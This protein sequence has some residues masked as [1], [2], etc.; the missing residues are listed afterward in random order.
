MNKPIEVG[1]SFAV[2]IGNGQFCVI[3]IVKV[4]RDDNM[5]L[6]AITPW[7]GDSIPDINEPLLRKILKRNRGK[8]TGSPAICWYSGKPLDN[9][10][11]I[12][13]IKPSV[14]ELEIDPKGRYGGEWNVNMINDIV[15]E[16]NI[17]ITHCNEISHSQHN[18]ATYKDK[19]S[20]E[21]FWEVISKLDWRKNDKEQILKPA[22]E[23]LSK[24]T[25]NEITGFYIVMC[26]KLYDLDGESYA[27][28]IGEYSYGSDE[29]F[30][31][32]HFLDVRCYVVAQGREYYENVRKKPTEMCKDREFE[33]LLSLPEIAYR[34]KTG[35]RPN[36]DDFGDYE[37][38]SN[39]EGWK[40]CI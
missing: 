12:G 22:I 5:A 2:P 8:F 35:K 4:S 10:E 29:G 23:Y 24:C 37:T 13:Q 30:S 34:M 11:Y 15:L 20:E 1:S 32:D 31:P 19:I 21:K 26:E 7:V 25:T 33:E 9:F 17:T 28:N 40:D 36:Y 18:N 3:R 16:Y 38:Y 14:E 39:K 6:V 27:R